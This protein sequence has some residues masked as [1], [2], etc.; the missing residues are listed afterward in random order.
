[1]PLFAAP[2][3]ESP[4]SRLVL[5]LGV[6]I[7][8]WLGFGHPLP[9]LPPALPPLVLLVPPLLALMGWRAASTGAAFRRGWLSAWAGHLLALYWLCLPI[10][11]VGGLPWVLA[12][13][14]AAFVALC[15]SSAGGLFAA[16]AH[17]LRRRSPIVL[18]LSLGLIWYLL[19]WGYA[20]VAGFPWL[21]LSGALAAWPLLIQ[22]ADLMGGYLL[23]G[24]W[25]AMLLLLFQLPQG[26][27]Y[28]L[29]ALALM[30]ACLGYGG[31]RLAGEP[32]EALPEG[33]GSFAV[34]LAEG[35]IDQKQKWLPAFQRATV[36]TYLRLTAG[37]L[38]AHPG[39]HPLIIWPETAMP[40]RFTP[41]NPLTRQVRELAVQAQ[42]PL[43]TGAPGF[44]GSGEAMRVYNRAYLIAPDGDLAGYYD[45]EHLVPFGEY[46]PEWLQ[47]NFLSGLLQE[48]GV[49][50]PGEQR[51]TAPLRSS[52]LELG[53]LI[54]YE[55]IF[56]WLAQQRVRDGA[57]VLADISNDGWFGRSPAGRQ[58]LYLTAVRAVEQNRWILRGTNTGISA[59][60]DPRGR[61][62]L[63]GGQFEE[64]ARWGRARVLTAT[65]PYHALAPWLPPGAALLLL[66]LIV[67]GPVRRNV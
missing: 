63:R 6:C 12:V 17:L 54:C 4:A 62:V 13:A 41:E 16:A 35:N 10:R 21:P 20:V 65:T 19:E 3:V 49:Y 30:A 60:I 43:L 37:M 42:A 25:A 50:T 2:P 52:G 57:N 56:P 58:H 39:E 59:I 36:Q 46:V 28:G 66:A 9:L 48:V 67:F 11:E 51:Q 18:A 55:G 7:C 1:M 33:P 23:A 5:P 34:L 14:C 24:L 22:P 26:R 64:T 53:M 29:L 8:L 15:L 40:F 32:A 47:W 27:R 38:A 31:W 45:K 44:E 61:I